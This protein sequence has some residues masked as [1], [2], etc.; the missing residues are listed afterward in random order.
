MT[1]LLINGHPKHRKTETEWDVAWQRKVRL[2]ITIQHDVQCTC[3]CICSLNKAPE[4]SR[5]LKG[6]LLWQCD[7]HL[8]TIGIDW[9]CELDLIFHS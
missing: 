8:D 4:E 2:T 5:Q 3:I 1:I 9:Q 6:A 7:L